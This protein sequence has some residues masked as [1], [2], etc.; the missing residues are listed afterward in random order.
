MSLAAPWD[1]EWIHAEG[2][3]LPCLHEAI[4]V[5]H[6]SPSQKVNTFILFICLL[7]D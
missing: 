1:I 4:Q 2:Q 3:L 6:I 7:F 5:I